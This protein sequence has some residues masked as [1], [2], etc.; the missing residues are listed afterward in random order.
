MQIRF[1]PSAN[2]D[3]ENIT[4]WYYKQGGAALALKM[5]RKIRQQIAILQEHPQIAPEYHM[6][7]VYRRLVVLEG[8]FLSSIG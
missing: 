1:L 2:Q 6:D 8:M 4:D 7:Q 3:L 5:T